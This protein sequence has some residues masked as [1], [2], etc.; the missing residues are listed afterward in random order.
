M[1]SH[2]KWAFGTT[3]LPLLLWVYPSGS[4]VPA[5]R[6]ILLPVFT[7]WTYEG[8]LS[9]SS[10]GRRYGSP[11][12]AGISLLIV[13]Q[14]RPRHNVCEVPNKLPRNRETAGKQSY[15]QNKATADT[16]N[17]LARSNRYEALAEEQECDES[18]ELNGSQPLGD[19]TYA[20]AVKRRR[21]PPGNTRKESLPSTT[22]CAD[23]VAALDHR[24][25]ELEAEM[26]CI[27]QRRATLAQRAKHQETPGSTT[28]AS[29]QR[30]AT[31][32]QRGQHHD[33]RA[34]PP[35][36]SA[37][38]RELHANSSNLTATELLTFVAE[39]LQHLAT[40][41]VA[42]LRPCW[43]QWPLKLRFDSLVEDNILNGFL[44]RCRLYT[45]L[46]T[47]AHL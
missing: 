21:Q 47:W 10:K 1:P 8:L 33:A 24:L 44:L 16:G 20:T 15:G 14:Q 38:L 39:Q 19:H 37:P 36:T 18:A 13:S 2:L 17:M 6:D 12:N 4:P 43:L 29:V 27:R 28:A 5:V 3:F 30:R 25:A 31:F 7:S 35:A 34:P 26:K 11:D 22:G 40:V 23:S 9:N 41:L 46:F 42:H 45:G 32:A